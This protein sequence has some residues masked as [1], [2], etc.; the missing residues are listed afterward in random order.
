LVRLAALLAVAGL[1][2]AACAPATNPP[3]VPL[4]QGGAIQVSVVD[5]LYDAGRSASVRLDQSGAPAVSYLLYQPVLTKGQI[6]PAVK[7]GDPQPPAVIL[8]TLAKG[9]WTRTSVTPQKTNPAEGDAPEIANANGQAVAGVTTSLAID[10][11]G[12]HHVAWATPKGLFYSTDAGGS[13]GAPDRVAGSP[14]FT[15]SVAV[16]ADG[17]VWIS[18]YSTGALK[19]A[20]GR[21]GA[22]TVDTVQPNSGPAAAPATVTAIAVGGNGDPVVAFGD[23]GTTGVARRAGGKWT[24]EKVPGAGGYGAS[25]ALDKSANPDVAY[26]DAA[27]GVHLAQS[28]AG[29][30]KV[31]DL[32]SSP[33]KGGT[34]DPRWSTG[35]ALDDK[36]VHYVTWADTAAGRI[37]AAADRNG[38]FGVRPVQGSQGGTNPSIAVSA[39]GQ[40]QAVAWFDSVNANLEVATSSE[41]SLALAFPLPTL[42]QPTGS[43]QPTSSGGPPACQPSGTTLKVTAK[44][45]AFDTNCLAAP[46][47]KAFTVDFDNQ[48]AGTPH[49]FE[50]YTDSSTTKRLGGATSAGDFIT[51]PATT[52]YK[53][54]ALPA[55]TYYFQCDIHPTQMFGT[56]VVA[57]G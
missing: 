40:K 56:F 32:G 21:A 3:D 53:V 41:G 10:A 24:I 49:N 50:I 11:Q 52:S 48:D 29:A 19:V 39:D 17:T 45:T 38:T 36:G 20:H 1:A 26:Y 15:G 51:G 54:D 7:P 46:A 47:E 8:A 12:K 27:G 16:A 42:Q 9:I 35:L 31:D 55:G 4:Q 2:G 18:F 37:V 25:L 13:F 5:S 44:N 43:P 6:P 22:W 33:G 14:S 30:W 23:H 28:K 57:K 34:S